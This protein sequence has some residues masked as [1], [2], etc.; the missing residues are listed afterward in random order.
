[1]T[2]AFVE[3]TRVLAVGSTDFR[4]MLFCVVKVS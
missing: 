2:L 3:M 1:M 4:V